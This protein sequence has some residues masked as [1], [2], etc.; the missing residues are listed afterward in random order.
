MP[1][2]APL[3]D[4]RFCLDH[5]V[6]AGALAE[7]DRYAE[8]TP[9]TVDAILTEMGKLADETLA[10]LQRPGDAGAHLEDGRVVLPEGYPEGLK[11]IAEGGWTGL[12][13][14]PEHGGMGLPLTLQTAVNEMQ[15]GACLSLSLNPLMTQGSIEALSA[16]ASPDLQ[17]RYLGKLISG[18]YAGTMNL[19]EPQAGSDVGALKTKAVPDG[20]HLQ[21]SGQK[22]Y[23]S[24]G[25]QDVTDNIVHLVLARLP[26][27]P[28]GRRGSA[29][30]SCP[31]I[32]RTDGARN[33]VKTVSL[34]HK[35]GLHGSPTCV[36]PTTM[37]DRLADRR[38]E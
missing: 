28:P 14:E 10:P 11:A 8:A 16:H 9:A 34:E 38:G 12:A 4:I 13:A 1:Y 22:I 33:G 31:N 37:R 15:A 7:T 35:L 25:D 17:E 29:C 6:G 18:A 36:W 2:K 27:A 21:I 26:D 30:S 3:K 20:E 32:L 24:W 19:T 5:I 23:I